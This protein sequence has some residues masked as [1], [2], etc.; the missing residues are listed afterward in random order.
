M[1]S[2]SRRLFAAVI[3]FSALSV[4]SCGD[5]SGAPEGSTITISPTESALTTSAYTGPTP[6]TSFSSED[7]PFA[8]TVR[9][10]NG[11]PLNDIDLVLSLDY[12]QGT[13]SGLT[14]LELYDNGARQTSPLR[15]KT[16]GSGTK[17][18]TVKRWHG[19]NI[20]YAGQLNVYSGSASAFADLS[21]TVEE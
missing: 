17:L 3:A 10:S 9:N 8:I 16:D 13:T 21:V 18:V 15:T 1:K 7:K 14:V 4:S 12:S 2:S 6:C 19:C 20:E 11:V 5:E